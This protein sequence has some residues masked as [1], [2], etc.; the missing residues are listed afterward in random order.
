MK[1]RHRTALVFLSHTLFC[2]PLG[3]VETSPLLSATPPQ[4][5][6]PAGR[7]MRHHY[8]ADQPADILH[9]RLELTF[10]ADGL[11]ARVCEGRVEYA[12]RPRSQ[13]LSSLK[14][15]AVG[16]T[17]LEVQATGITPAPAFAYDDKVLTI[18]WPKPIAPDTTAKVAIRYRLNDPPKGMHFVLPSRS[19][20]NRPT[21]VYTMSE[22]IEARYWVPAHDWPNDAGPRISSS[23][24]PSR[25]LR[26]PTACS[27]KSARQQTA[28]PGPFTGATRSPPTR[29]SWVWQSAN[30]WN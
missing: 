15:E 28:S 5:S 30:W 19:A 26:W 2:G 22:P 10:T 6:A 18:Q 29:T 4:A 8:T 23:P 9:M 11:R 3:L 21:M 17:V 24:C 20:P 1:T 13:S 16:M 27:L 7:D 14:L 25:F 12:F